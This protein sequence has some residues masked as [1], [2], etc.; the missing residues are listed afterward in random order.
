VL[1]ETVLSG[2]PL[3]SQK[4][5]FSNHTTYKTDNGQHFHES[6]KIRQVCATV[7]N[8]LIYFSNAD[9]STSLTPLGSSGVSREVK[10]ITEFK[11][12]SLVR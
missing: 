2:D 7:T 12:G 8:Q 4:H 3:Y 1:L 11:F 9:N 10:L 5:F 6:E